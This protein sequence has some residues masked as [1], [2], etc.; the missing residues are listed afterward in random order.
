VV[1]VLREGLDDPAADPYCG[2]RTPAAELLLD[3]ELLD[4]TA[5]PRRASAGA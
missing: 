5:A 1:G 4:G 3:H 2:G